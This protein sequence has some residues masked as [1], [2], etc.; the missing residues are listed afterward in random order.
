MQLGKYVK[1]II[2]IV[3]NIFHID[4]AEVLMYIESKYEI[5]FGNNFR[6]VM[7]DVVY[8]SATPKYSSTSTI[9]RYLHVYTA[10][11]PLFCY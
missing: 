6:Y 11:L 9:L 10:S 7:Y 3:W 5:I 2:R 4:Y 1:E 8:Y